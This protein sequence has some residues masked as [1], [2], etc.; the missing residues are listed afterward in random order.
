MKK[1]EK[2]ITALFIVALGVLLICLRGELIKLLM[3]VLG[4]GLIALGVMDI[5]SKQIPPAIVKIVGGIVAIVC[6]WTIV[7]VV[8]Y[9]I[10]AVL[11]VCGIL[12][13]Y[14]K[15]KRRVNCESILSAIFEYATSVFFVVIGLLLLFNQGNTVN[16]VFIT[17]GIFTILEGAILFANAVV[18]D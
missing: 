12:L 17:V 5:F 1:T 14:D 18:G 4:L 8:L 16:W 10:A 15:Y 7:S 13:L 6:G 2:I 9:L 11:L 3:T